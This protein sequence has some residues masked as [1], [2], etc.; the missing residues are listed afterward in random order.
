MKL[1]EFYCPVCKTI[2]IK[3]IVAVH[4]QKGFKLFCLSCLTSKWFNY[5]KIRKFEIRTLG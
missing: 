1:F 5:H 4:R 2:T 3:K